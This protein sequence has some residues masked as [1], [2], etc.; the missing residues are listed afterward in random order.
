MIFTPIVGLQAI[1]G[2]TAREVPETSTFK[3]VVVIVSKKS[4]GIFEATVE[5]AN[6]D[7]DFSNSTF[8]QEAIAYVPYVTKT[9]GY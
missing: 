7:P 2:E 9:A 5:G 8:E 3:P 1:R 4:D 6:S